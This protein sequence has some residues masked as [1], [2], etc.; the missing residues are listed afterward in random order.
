MQASHL[1]S[2]RTFRKVGWVAQV[3]YGGKYI[4]A[5]KCVRSSD[6]KC[7]FDSMLSD[8]DVN[9]ELAGKHPD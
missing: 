4:N 1:V 7:S 2:D 9:L 8:C 3:E 5:R 6:E